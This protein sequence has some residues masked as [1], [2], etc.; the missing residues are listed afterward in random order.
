MQE[1]LLRPAMLSGASF[2]SSSSSSFFCFF[3]PYPSS[4]SPLDGRQGKSP[5]VARA[6][7]GWRGGI[8]RRR[9]GFARM[10]DG[11]DVGRAAWRPLACASAK[12]RRGRGGG[13]LVCGVA[14]TVV[15]VRDVCVMILGEEEQ[16]GVRLTG[17]AQ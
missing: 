2:S 14:I 1:E 17:G 13:Q 10:V 5:K 15:L 6:G 4:S 16:G 11:G 3:F 7:S 8:C 9:L 12:A